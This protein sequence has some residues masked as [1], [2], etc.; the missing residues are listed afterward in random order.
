MQRVELGGALLEGRTLSE[1]FLLLGGALGLQRQRDGRLRDLDLELGLDLVL[2]R[3][4]VRGR[5]RVRRLVLVADQ[6]LLEPC[7]T[8]L[9]LLLLTGGGSLSVLTRPLI[10]SHTGHS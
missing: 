3:H 5:E 4:Y 9:T 1:R 6:S 2:S 8:L 10:G 7:F